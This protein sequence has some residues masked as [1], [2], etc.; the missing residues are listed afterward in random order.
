[1]P[2]VLLKEDGE[3][4]CDLRGV[5][6]SVGAVVSHDGEHCSKFRSDAVMDGTSCGAKQ[7]QGHADSP[8]AGAGVHHPSSPSCLNLL[9]PRRNVLDASCRMSPNR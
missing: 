2:L 1:M 7:R 5:H 3:T 6:G 4:S 8:P 9:P